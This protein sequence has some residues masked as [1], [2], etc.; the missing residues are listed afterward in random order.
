MPGTLL[1]GCADTKITQGLS[2]GTSAAGLFSNVPAAVEVVVRAT[3]R[4]ICRGAPLSGVQV[5]LPK[6]AWHGDR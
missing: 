5:T 6:S 3:V 4:L 2:D 1:P